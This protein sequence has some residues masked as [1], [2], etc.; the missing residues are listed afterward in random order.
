MMICSG[1][2]WQR[3][4]Q[5]AEGSEELQGVIDEEEADINQADG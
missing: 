3:F 4:M 5:E 1:R 2:C